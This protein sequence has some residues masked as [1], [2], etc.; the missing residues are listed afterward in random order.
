[1]T[2]NDVH[3]IKQVIEES[4]IR[5][6]HEEQNRALIDEGFHSAFEML[7]L[8][9]K[10]VSRVNVDEWMPRI[11]SMKESNPDMWA[12]P[13]SHEFQLID[14]AGNAAVAKLDVYKGD[15]FFSVDY[16]LLYKIGG[17]W[18]IVS[19]VFSV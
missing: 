13:T 1:M 8:D 15:E 10:N 11:E 19:K 3:D 17:K 6:I 2:E 14:V 9:D 12:T 5:G 16:M 4:Y 7:V 18:Q